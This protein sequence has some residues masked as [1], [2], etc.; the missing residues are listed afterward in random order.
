MLNLFRAVFS[1]P[2]DLILL[3]A[4]A[5]F[6]LALADRRAKQSFVGEKA[7]DALVGAMA[8]AF[9]IGGRVLY[10]ASHLSAFI[11][12]PGSLISPN[13]GLFDA[14]GGLAAAALAAAIVMQ[15]KRLPAW[16]TLDL[17][18]PFVA[19]T[20]VGL[21][22]THLA[23]GAAFGRETNVPWAIYMWGAQRHPTQIYELLAGVAILGA[24]WIYGSRR[25]RAGQTFLIWLALAAASRLAI[26]GFR[27]DSTL[28]LGGLRIAQIIAWIVLAA[29]LLALEIRQAHQ[30]PDAD[31]VAHEPATTEELPA[32]S[33][34][35]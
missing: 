8:L 14:G 13:V 30:A 31:V 2:R 25:T 21:A 16:H 11:S 35:E 22:L 27:G 32:P 24:V 4:A 5:W 18:A 33:P 20:A 9:L 1:P 15:R 3:V 7:M 26:E 10:A 28:V 23:S 12:S 34:R 19:A 29:A 6:G 17:L